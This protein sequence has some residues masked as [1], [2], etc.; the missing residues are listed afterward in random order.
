MRFP[1]DNVLGVPDS[2]QK[3]VDAYMQELLPR[4][5][6]MR[7]IAREN[8]MEYQKQYKKVYDRN[9][10]ASNYP[11]GT[12][13]L[14]YSPKVPTGKS[15][16]LYI[17][18]KGP[19]YI[20]LQTSPSNYII[21]DCKT[22]VA[23]THP[24][25]A[26]RLRVYSD[27]DVFHERD[28]STGHVSEEDDDDKSSDEQ[29]AKDLGQDPS[30]LV[31]TESRQLTRKEPPLT[32]SNKDV[33]KAAAR[34]DDKIS[35]KDEETETDRIRERQSTT[36]SRTKMSL[37]DDM[38]T[39]PPRK[40][41]SKPRK[42]L[43]MRRQVS[44]KH[45]GNASSGDDAASGRIKQTEKMN[46]KVHN[47]MKELK[48]SKEETEPSGDLSSGDDSEKGKE[49]TP[50]ATSEP[51]L[52]PSS[53]EKSTLSQ[54]KSD[55]EEKSDWETEN[56]TESHANHTG[57]WCIAKKLAGVKKINGRRHYKVIWE[58]SN[59]S[60]S[61]IVEDDISDLLKE[62]YHIRHTQRGAIRKTMK[63]KRQI[64]KTADAIEHD[65]LIC[66]E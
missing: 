51:Q 38:V 21:R 64:M 55:V 11:P 30:R 35:N 27:R 44:S 3:N 36:K 28:Q 22:H 40:K 32:D 17:K 26:D 19:Y 12:R 9:S 5:E 53:L 24:V 13:V 37:G 46:R 58:D 47:V 7:K 45:T 16:K 33:R 63:K 49:T 20:A 65:E 4:L 56:E 1:I 52:I 8:V 14:L 66:D 29:T 2:E 18:W 54:K 23:I 59:A 10:E 60:P 61:W 62:T 57:E 48:T 25:H 6:A 42:Q 41:L 31:E 50:T 43:K 15:S 34:R 39:K